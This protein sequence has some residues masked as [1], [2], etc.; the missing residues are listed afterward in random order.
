MHRESDALFIYEA[1]TRV[2]RLLDVV[3]YFM[4]LVAGGKREFPFGRN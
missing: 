4:H 3:A 2:D 1:I